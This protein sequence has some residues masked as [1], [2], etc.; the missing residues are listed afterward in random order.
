MLDFSFLNCYGYCAFARAYTLKHKRLFNGIYGSM[1]NNVYRT[2]PFYKKFL[3]TV[4]D[5]NVLHT[6]GTFLEVKSCTFKKQM[7]HLGILTVNSGQNTY[8]TYHLI[9]VHNPY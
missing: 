2:F 7:H 8:S 6:E 4:A 5:K 3:Y 9:I 1:K